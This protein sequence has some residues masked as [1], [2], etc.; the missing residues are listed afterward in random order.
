MLSVEITN[1][2]GKESKA[3]LREV[4]LTD[5]RRYADAAGDT[6]PLY[7]DDGYAASSRFKGAIAPPDFFGWPANWTPG[8]PNPAIEGLFDVFLAEVAKLGIFR[9][10]NG[11]V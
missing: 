6:N 3:S 1:L 2:I 11:G 8:N 9:V 10:L 5:I 4:H 7:W